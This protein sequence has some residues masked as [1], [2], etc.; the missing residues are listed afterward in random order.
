MKQLGWILPAFAGIAL[1]VSAAT[2]YAARV[3]S[4]HPGT[5][6]ADGFTNTAAVLG[7]PSRLNPF[8]D[9]TEPFNPAYGKDQVLSIGEGGQVTI[10]FRRPVFNVL[11]RPFGLDF[12]IFGNS[13]FIVT[14]EFD[15]E[16]FGWIG[17]P[18][19]D[20]SLFGHN[21]GVTR[22]SVSADGRRFFTLDPELAPEVDVLFPTDGA[23]SFTLPVNPEVGP[24]DFAGATHEIIREWYAG[25]GG[26]AGFNVAWARSKKGRKFPLRFI[27]FVRVE[28]LQGRV[29]V[30]G[31]AATARTR[32]SR[33][34]ADQP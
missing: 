9:A 14:N 25:S 23:G 30:D 18:A 11:R 24:D 26:G 6:H 31:F 33:Q 13:G 20:G 2:N 16:T 27:R 19:T 34:R 1:N 10:K 5:D 8:D 4:Y 15:P 17:T 3:I 32:R 21:S 28:V 22:V 12:I 29:E 7:E